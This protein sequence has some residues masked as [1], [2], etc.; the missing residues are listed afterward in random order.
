MTLELHGLIDI[1]A[2]DVDLEAEAQAGQGDGPGLAL[3][4]DAEVKVSLNV[5]LTWRPFD[6][7]V[8]KAF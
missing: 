7:V 1:F 6:R 8:K 2:S 4:Y 5:A 3:R